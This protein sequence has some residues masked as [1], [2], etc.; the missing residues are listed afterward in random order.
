MGKVKHGLIKSPE[1]SSWEH[2]KRRCYDS[3]T[4]SYPRY[5]GR[6]IGVCERWLNSFES[7]YS[8]MGQRPSNK[9]SLDR[10]RV[11]ENYSPNNCKWSTFTEQQRNRTDN[12]MVEYKGEM[13]CMSE[14]AIKLKLK[15]TTVFNRFYYGW[16]LDR[17]INTP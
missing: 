11:N 12:R 1:Y 10:I 17:I 2:M 14:L 16:S 3:K 15:K 13:I 8:D 7:F 4:E 9:H 6:G 5:G